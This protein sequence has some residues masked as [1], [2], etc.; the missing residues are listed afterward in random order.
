[1][2][3]RVKKR[4]EPRERGLGEVVG[5]PCQA[6]PCGLPRGSEGPARASGHVLP[7]PLRGGLRPRSPRRARVSGAPALGA[8]GSPCAARSSST[9][10]AEEGTSAARPIASRTEAQRT[11]PREMTRQRNCGALL[12]LWPVLEAQR[13]P[14]GL[15]PAENARIPRRCRASIWLHSSEVHPSTS[16]SRPSAGRF[17]Q[18][19]FL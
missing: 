2:V 14:G 7:A 9:L 13:Y 4:R 17:E 12:L 6:P 3:L 1:M 18:V 19:C 11:V 10:V 16:Q 8:G 5:L 15:A